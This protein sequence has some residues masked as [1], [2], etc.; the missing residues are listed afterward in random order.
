MIKSKRTIDSPKIKIKCFKIIVS[1]NKKEQPIIIKQYKTMKIVDSICEIPASRNLW[2]KLLLSAKNGLLPEIPLIVNTRRVSKKGKANKAK[3]KTG[4]LSITST[5][6]N[7]VERTI[8][9]NTANIKPITREP[10]FPMKILSWPLL[11]LNLKKAKILPNIDEIEIIA[12][13]DFI[14]IK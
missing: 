3:M 4:L 13:N 14:F 7:S 2:R 5:E 9:V 11:T 8:V 12:K 1:N 6:L 10:T